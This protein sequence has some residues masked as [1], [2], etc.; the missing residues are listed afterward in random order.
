MH[1][2]KWIIRGHSRNSDR[3]FD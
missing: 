3:F 1:N 2:C